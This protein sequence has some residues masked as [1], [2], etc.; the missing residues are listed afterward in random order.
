MK[1]KLLMLGVLSYFFS[2][3]GYA[4]NTSFNALT[5]N[6][7][8]IPGCMIPT[9]DGNVLLA[10][11]IES[12]STNGD[13]L[14][15][16]RDPDGSRIWATRLNKSNYQTP[17]GLWALSDGG[18]LIVGTTSNGSFGGED[19]ILIK[20]DG[21]G[22]V[23]W[24]K[25]YGGIQEDR[26]FSVL[27]TSNG[28]IMIAGTTISFGSG[29]R[30]AYLI[31]T[32]ADG[33]MLWSRTYGGAEHDNFF[34]IQ[35]G[36]GNTFVLTG[37][38]FSYGQGQHDIWAMQLDELGNIIW[39]NLFGT[40]QDEH[41][42]IIRPSP[43]GGWFILGHRGPGYQVAYDGLILKLNDQGELQWTRS[44]GGAGRELLGNFIINRS[45]DRML[46]SGHTNSTPSG[47]NDIFYVDLDLQGNLQEAFTLGGPG[48][49]ELLFGAQ[50]TLLERTNGAVL[51][52]GELQINGK[53]EILLATLNGN[54]VEN[55]SIESWVPDLV[56]VSLISNSA[57]PTLNTQP[58][59][60]VSNL[61]FTN[62]NYDPA[63]RSYCQPPPVANFTV[64][65][66]ICLSDCITPVDNSTD[67][68]E[69]WQWTIQNGSE[70]MRSGPDPGP[71]CFDVEGEFAIK[72]VVSNAIGSDSIT[73][74]VIVSATGAACP[75]PPVANFSVPDSLC[76]GDCMTPVDNSTGMPETWEWTIQNGSEIVRSGP[77]PGPVCFDTEG[78]FAIKLVVSNPLGSDSLTQTII[79]ST[80]GSACPLP[81]VAVFSAPDTICAGQCIDLLENS[82]GNPDTWSWTFDGADT[83]VSAET[84]PQN[85]CY[86]TA[87]T[88]T[89]TLVVANELGTDTFSQSLTVLP[90]PEVDL[91][92]DASLCTGDSL[93]LDPLIPSGFSF[94][95]NDGFPEVDRVIRAAGTYQL[96]VFNDFCTTE[97]E[98]SITS[99]FCETCNVYIPN[100]FSPNEDGINDAFRPYLS[101][102][103]EDYQLQIFDRWGNQVCIIQ[104]DPDSGWDGRTRGQPAPV[105]VYVY[106]LELQW[107]EGENMV[108]KQFTGD[109]TLV[110]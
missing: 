53:A 83:P 67:M 59:T 22:N 35:P 63:L 5:A 108:T 73:K 32:D 98:I 20:T 11:I 58:N 80:T 71:V 21:T 13:I 104:G 105:G 31:Q 109:V 16:L 36:P 64:P 78:E 46:I 99:L 34:N 91:G 9:P 2:A 3:V 103:V 82:T 25:D 30:D 94:R 110:R 4:Q 86:L 79:V 72:L 41:S 101:C 1:Y 26:G 37:P 15:T 50:Q 48:E 106:L 60:Q 69:T 93:L 95:W 38:T 47:T 107:P 102:P 97:D 43:D 88:F 51:L 10:G 52:T 18:F 27:E 77:D 68:P 49:D 96:E 39:A 23:L 62:E 87:G 40:S 54:A 92:P 29:E 44:F 66:S 12:N 76:L 8:L 84:E 61:T 89:I 42:R 45:A 17:R 74:T 19:I 14:L 28:N 70:I 55:C 6:E 85:I 7:S 57:N 75:L 65:D 56:N 24:A 81:P 100:V 33:N 90:F